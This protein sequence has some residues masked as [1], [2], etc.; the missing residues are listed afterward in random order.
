MD[1]EYYKGKKEIQIP[2]IRKR[3]KENGKGEDGPGYLQWVKN[4]KGKRKK[5]KSQREKEKE[6]L[7]ER[8]RKQKKENGKGKYGPGNLQRGKTKKEEEKEKEKG[9]RKKYQKT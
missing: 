1:R 8:I 2:R 4:E 7:I 6:I 3:K 5:G 9:K